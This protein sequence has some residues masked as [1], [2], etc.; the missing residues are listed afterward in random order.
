MS[1]Q[2]GACV[3][4]VMTLVGWVRLSELTFAG[5]STGTLQ[6]GATKLFSPFRFTMA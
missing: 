2:I 1:V 5:S 6:G 3:V 4:D